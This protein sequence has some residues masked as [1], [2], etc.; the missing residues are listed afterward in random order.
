M[1]SSGY[2]PPL[3]AFAEFN[4]LSLPIMA[5]QNGPY[6]ALIPYLTE[7]PVGWKYSREKKKWNAREVVYRAKQPVPFVDLRTGKLVGHFDPR[8]PFWL[9]P[10]LS[11]DGKTLVG[12]VS[13]PPRN[14]FQ[15]YSVPE[16]KEVQLG[17]Q[18]LYAWKRDSNE[19]PKPMLIDGEVKSMTFANDRALVLLV[20]GEQRRVEVWD[21]LSVNARAQSRWIRL[22]HISKKSLQSV[23]GPSITYNNLP[24]FRACSQLVLVANTPQ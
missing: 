10:I 3:A 19:V 13:E 15:N 7:A 1:T 20:E 4:P 22:L 12:P 14:D 9:S 2:Y 17:R 6:M 23:E 16:E 18:T 24:A 11:P 5:S 21:T 8:A